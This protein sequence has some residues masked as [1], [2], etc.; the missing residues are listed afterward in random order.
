MTAEKELLREKYKTL[1]LAMGLEEVIS[2]SRAICRRLMAE[3]D[4]I[5][6]KRMHIYNPM[7]RLN[8]VDTESFLFHTQNLN[9]EVEITIISSGKG[10]ILPNEKFDLILV[11]TLAFDKD[12]Y[13]L[14]WGGG[15]Y[16]KFLAKQPQALKIGL[17][18][19]NGFVENDLPHE[20]HDIPLDKIITEYI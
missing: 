7:N 15:F 6:I 18:F 9:P 5:E 1:R 16:D 12:N 17:C 4:W 14:G 13:R 2:K 19:Q 8:E 11:P 3:L 10:Q 20:P